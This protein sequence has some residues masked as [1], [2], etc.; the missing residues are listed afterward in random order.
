MITRR[1]N[2][3]G[4]LFD[5]LFDDSTPEK[6][7]TSF[8]EDPHWYAI[9]AC[10]MLRGEG[11]YQRPFTRAVIDAQLRK[12]LVFWSRAD[13]RDLDQPSEADREFEVLLL[14]HLHLEH[15]KE[16]DIYRGYLVPGR[17]ALA[18]VRKLLGGRG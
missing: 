4:G 7:A 15:R 9:D 16:T 1:Q 2:R 3:D 12:T 6:P 10:H 18:A 8:R 5:E 11:P 14:K 13:N 17:A